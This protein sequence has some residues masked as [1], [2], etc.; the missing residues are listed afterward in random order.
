MLIPVVV[1]VACTHWLLVSV[2]LV[3]D[4][5]VPRPR[6]RRVGIDDTHNLNYFGTFTLSLI[7]STRGACC[8]HD[9][10]VLLRVLSRCA[11][12]PVVGG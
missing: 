1:L 6:P 5:L 7:L 12:L 8:P 2:V 9:A 10:Y 4:L 3:L 11:S